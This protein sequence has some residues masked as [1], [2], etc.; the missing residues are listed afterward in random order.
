M[1]D[2]LSHIRVC[3]WDLDGT[4]YPPTTALDQEIHQQI[5]TALADSLQYSLTA[6]EDYYQTKKKQLKST[7]KVLNSAKIDGH[8]F[9]I[10]LWLALDLQKYI[11]PNPQLV[12]LFAQTKNFRHVLHTN[13]NTQETIRRKLD[14]LGLAVTVFSQIMTSAEIGTTKPDVRAFTYLIDQVAVP[15]S[16]ILY[17]GDR[18]DVDLLPARELGMHTCL[19]TNGT[20]VSNSGDIDLVFDTPT[21]LLKTL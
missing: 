21:D 11:Q 14:C 16:Q 17:I 13:S 10:N 5:I 18:I 8:Q 3:A 15:V 4:L 2:W 7:T 9:F 6:A 19:I 20:T 12:K 1:K